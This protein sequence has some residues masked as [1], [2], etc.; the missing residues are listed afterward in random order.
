[1][2]RPVWAGWLRRQLRQLFGVSDVHQCRAMPARELLRGRH[3]PLWW[4]VQLPGQ[5]RWCP[6]LHQRPRPLPQLQGP[7]RRGLCPGRRG[8]RLCQC[9]GRPLHW[10]SGHRR[11]CLPG[12][13]RSGGHDRGRPGSAAHPAAVTSTG[14][15]GPCP[16][17]LG[18]SRDDLR[19]HGAVKA[20]GADNECGVPGGFRDWWD[21]DDAAELA[22]LRRRV[23]EAEAER[24]R[25]AATWRNDPDEPGRRRQGHPSAG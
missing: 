3:E 11:L 22:A 21:S 9:C 15:G 20:C 18:V 17:F 23:A 16:E 7:R 24:E 25:I 14:A 2:P 10:L 19:I 1:M 5:V 4:R 8:L 12:P 13:V 6:V